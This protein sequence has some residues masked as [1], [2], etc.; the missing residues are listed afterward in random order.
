MI[1]QK[2]LFFSLFLTFILLSCGSTLNKSSVPGERNEGLAAYYA[3]SLHGNT[4][5]SGEPYNKN[6]LT[7]AHRHLPFGT[8]VKVTN[9]SNLKSVKVKINDRGPFGNSK[10]IIDLSRKAAA[11]ISMISA[12]IVKVRLEVIDMP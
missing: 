8:M 5:A 6:A 10:R 1:L 7:A 2:Y 9:L 11:R 12:G 4:T 3:D